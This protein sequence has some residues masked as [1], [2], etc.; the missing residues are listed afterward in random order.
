MHKEKSGLH[1]YGNGKD[2]GGIFFFFLVVMI[3]RK[4]IE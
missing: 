2:D 3:G 1:S 4:E